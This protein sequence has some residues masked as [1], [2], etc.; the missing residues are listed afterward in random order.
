[1]KLII[2]QEKFEKHLQNIAKALDQNPHLMILKGLMI[3]ANE[4]NIQLIASNGNLSIKE[5]ISTNADFNVQES[6]KILVPGKIF[7]QLIKKQEKVISLIAEKNQLKIQSKGF[8]SSV[9]LLNLEEYPMIKFDL[10]GEEGKEIVL[11][12]KVI[13]NA[14]RNV[15][16]A[17]DE[18]NDNIIYN[19][20]NFKAKDNQLQVSA[21]NKFRIARELFPLN[22][23]TNLNITIFAKN[24]KDF[25]PPEAKGTIK[26]MLSDAKMLASYENT[27]IV[28][29]LIDG[30]FPEVDKH[31]P[32]QFDSSL[33]IDVYHLLSLID[34]ASTINKEY[35]NTLTFRINPKEL[36]IES[37]KTEIGNIV[38][39]T[40]QMVWTGQNFSITFNGNYLKEAITKFDANI[41]LNFLGS[42]KQFIITGNS[43]PDLIQF[44]L[45]HRRHQ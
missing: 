31:I 11:D 6:G 22:Q 12:A 41:T 35:Q 21:T 14:I 40:N 20:V 4:S 36:V 29:K 37:G 10:I 45:P 25:L 44:I 1:M 18:R 13:K 7:I 42:E 17:A 30:M 19:G 23:K 3:I 33:T 24:L 8:E 28:L 34:K 2:N 43:N 5:V 38:V 39:K 27:T 32:T 15:A 9:N 26:V 16:F